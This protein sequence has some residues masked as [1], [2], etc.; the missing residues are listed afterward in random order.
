MNW[1]RLLGLYAQV[2]AVSAVSLF[3]FTQLFADVRLTI[4]VAAIAAI[5]FLSLILGGLLAGSAYLY[6]VFQTVW[7]RVVELAWPVAVQQLSRTL[8]RTTD[9]FITALFAPA[10][11]VAIGLAELYAQGPLW[12]GLG[13]GNAAI[14]LS[15]Q[16][17]GRAASAGRDEVITQALLFGAVL[18]V[19]VA[20]V[21]FVF[22]PTLIAVFGASPTVVTL[23][24]TYLTIILVTAPARHVAL[25]GTQAL[26]GI[27]DTKTPMYI[28]VF[29]NLL[30]IAGS[31][32]LGLGLFGAPELRVVGVGLATAGAN[33]V[34][35]LLIVLAIAGPWS[36]GGLARP[37]SPAIAR[38][39]VTV[40]LPRTVEGLTVAV[41][42][43]PFNA[44]LL[45]F[46]TDVNAGYQI[47][48]RVY[49]QITAP[50]S[51]AY[52]VTASIMAGQALGAGDAEQARFDARAIAILGVL[53]LGT[54][55]VGMVV[56]AEP[57]A[58]LFTDDLLARQYSVGFIRVYGL[59]AVPMILFYTLAGSLQGGSETRLPLF[60]RATGTF[61][62]L[63]GVSYVLG[64]VLGYGPVGAYVGV[65]LSFVW[66]ALVLLWWFRRGDWTERA[67]EMIEERG[68]PSESL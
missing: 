56:A 50:L 10:A 68:G 19:P 31:V 7:R 18:G 44:L 22:G 11:V 42:R 55:G 2:V 53:S 51:R 35:A 28:N 59:V 54:I 47:G 46:G 63:L 62:F 41:A 61:G 45:A 4:A 33:V 49:Q 14:S 17:T 12:I 48:Y 24:G 30:N 3:V 6:Y 40:G 37:R 52:Q 60:A 20:I 58:A 26:Q 23:G 13:L 8:M 32:V 66:M 39:L 65:G 16:E 25:V 21:G 36:E 43:F 5:A 1:K 15:S 27:G 29:G 67:A 64:S 38:Q 34:S 57:L 9:V